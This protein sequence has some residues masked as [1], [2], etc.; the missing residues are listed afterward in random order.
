MERIVKT[1]RAPLTAYQR[2]EL[3]TGACRYPLPSFYSGYGS[4]ETGRDGEAVD[5]YI[6]DQMKND[7]IDNRELLLKLWDG[8]I[9]ELDVFGDVKPWLFIT[10]ADDEQPWAATMFDEPS[11]AARAKKSK[12]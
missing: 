4:S 1:E 12:R 3:L 6:G 2:F 7:R 8:E 10:H 11:P 5:Q 9:N